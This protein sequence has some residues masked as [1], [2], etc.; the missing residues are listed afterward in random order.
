MGS[1][2][3]HNVLLRSTTTIRITD[4]T[5]THRPTAAMT[6][7]ATEPSLAILRT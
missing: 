5:V 3:V 2:Q 1:G 4:T 6:T 7:A